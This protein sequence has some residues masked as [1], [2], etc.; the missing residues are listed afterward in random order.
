MK[1]ILA[2]LLSLVM[3]LTLAACAED[4]TPDTPD[5]TDNTEHTDGTGETENS[6][7]LD[8]V[9]SVGF[10]RADIT[11]AYSVPLAGYGN[12]EKRMS[13][14]FYDLNYTT[15]TAFTGANG[16]TVLL[17]HNDAIRTGSNIVELCRPLISQA[18][19]VPEDHIMISA[20]HNHSSPDSSLSSNAAITQWM[21][22]LAGAMTDAAVEAMADRKPAEMYIASTQVVGVGFTRHYVMDDGSIC[23]DNFSGTGTKVVGHA[24][25]SDKTLQL[26]K[27]VR[28]GGKDIVMANYQAHPHAGGGSTLTY[29]TSDIVGSFRDMMEEQTDCLFTYFTGGS[30]NI[31]A[32]S[33]IAEDMPYGSDY[34]SLGQVLAKAAIEAAST[35]KQV[36]TGDVAITTTSLTLNIDHNDDDKIE[37]GR[38][39]AELWKT[40]NNF[41]LCTSEGKQ[42]GIKSPY[43]ANAIVRKYALDK[44][45]VMN[46]INAFTIGDVAFVTVPYEMFHQSGSYIKENSPFDMT[47]IVTCA[48]GANSYIPTL[49]AYEYY[50]YECCLCTYEKGTAE[51]LAETYVD[52]LNSL[53]KK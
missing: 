39:I 51:K 1:K 13:T 26:I 28:E 19:G 29:I 32:K 23:G 10:G 4:N 17:Y 47:F 18:T 37:G 20:T 41:D 48:N 34:I 46:E 15:C 38:I 16:E 27:F 11:P 52:L 45:G 22:D 7:S 12:T 49:D 40:T 8:G 35:Y 53:Y 43:H 31:N 36:E 14:C 6:V 42:Y 2:L 50:S 33:R 44:T 3:L 5:T 9:F 30:G 24:N 21:S 25:E